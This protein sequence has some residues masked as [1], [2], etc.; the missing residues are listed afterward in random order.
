MSASLDEPP[1][2]TTTRAVVLPTPAPVCA[3]DG[4][5]LL[6]TASH[7]IRTPMYGLLGMLDMALSTELTATQRHYMALARASAASLATLVNDLLDLSKLQSGHLTVSPGECDLHRV[8][9]ESLGIFSVRA[10]ARNIEFS[11]CC[12]AHLAQWIEI[13]ATRLLQV[14]GNLV[15]N[16]IKFTSVG[17]VSVTIATESISGI[18]HLRVSVRDTGP[19]IAPADLEHI[20]RPFAQFHGASSGSVPNTGL[21][22][23]ITRS[24]VAAMG[25][26]MVISSEPG[27]GSCFEAVLPAP[28][29]GNAQAPRTLGDTICLSVQDDGE[30]EQ[31]AQWLAAM[32]CL[33]VG[34]DQAEFADAVVCDLSQPVARQ[35]RL[36][37]VLLVPSSGTAT[38]ALDATTTGSETACAYKPLSPWR[39]HRLLAEVLGR[40]G[41]QPGPHA[42]SAFWHRLAGARVLLVDD[43]AVSALVSQS[44]LEMIGVRVTAS[45]TAREA[46]AALMKEAFDVVLTDLRLPGMDGYELA[47]WIRDFQQDIPLRRR[48]IVIALSAST[49]PAARQHCL[50]VGMDDFVAKPVPREQLYAVLLKHAEQRGPQSPARFFVN[51]AYGLD[52]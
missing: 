35:T 19:G 9:D 48:S 42:D 25:G 30:R 49:A 44:M 21:G 2:A 5:D 41:P 47:R 45:A 51:T 31:L 50:D 14:L 4:G 8:L 7:E 34:P 22:L 33:C 40:E 29:L 52:S 43:D 13:D 12:D 3:F 1:P 10:A 16:A 11:L 6:T 24:L 15:G 18:H 32:G 26:H 39:L 46:T 37:K 27:V 36:P 20:F 38:A 23:T 17:R 28:S